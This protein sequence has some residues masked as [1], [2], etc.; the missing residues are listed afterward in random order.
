MSISKWA[1]MQN[2]KGAVV[3]C[4]VVWVPPR[5]LVTA[6]ILKNQDDP[7]RCHM[8]NYG[9]HPSRKCIHREERTLYII[10]RTV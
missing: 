8:T 3:W 5:L 1:A 2:K 9:I 10:K 7:S 6:Q 4:G